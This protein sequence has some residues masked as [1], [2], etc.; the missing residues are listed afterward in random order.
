[1]LEQEVLD[2]LLQDIEDSF[3]VLVSLS[4]VTVKIKALEINNDIILYLYH[5]PLLKSYLAFLVEMVHLQN[6]FLYIWGKAHK[7]LSIFQTTR[8]IFQTLLRHEF[9]RPWMVFHY[10]DIALN[11]LDFIG[12]KLV[13]LEITCSYPGIQILSIVLD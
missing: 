11:E 13:T 5:V 12:I 2:R 7:S 8:S 10:P 9:Y 4:R 3:P 1:M 6:I